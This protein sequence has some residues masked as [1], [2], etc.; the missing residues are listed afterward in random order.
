[1]KLDKESLKSLLENPHLDHSGDNFI[2][3]CPWC[4]KSE[5]GIAIYEK[6]HPFGC[7]RKKKC[8]Q[9]GNIYDLIKKIG[10]SKQFLVNEEKEFIGHTIPLLNREVKK[11]IEQL[12]SISMPI[13]YKRIYNHPYLKSRGFF[14]YDKYEVGISTLDPKLEKYYVIFPVYFEGSIKGYV[15][16]V[17]FSKEE[18]I[19]FNHNNGLFLER[20]RNSKT[21]FSQLLYGYDEITE[22][23]DTLIL[24]EG[25]F[26]KFNIDRLLGLWSQEEIKC[27][28][29]FGAKLSNHQIV[30]IKEKKIKNIIMLVEQDVVGSNKKISSYIMDIFN[31]KLG[32][33]PENID[34]GDFTEL[35][36]DNVFL[37]LLDPLQ[38]N[39]NSLKLIV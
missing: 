10:Y 24:V 21:D 29:T 13:G 15:S 14:E 7:F 6:N 12:D 22:N 9:T 18:L 30:K 33:C 37:N 19:D 17:I 39:L 20:F 34:P 16:R 23:T 27:C 38:Y 4:G 31:V 3:N 5:F 8:G 11:T 25:I 1:M 26:S 32:V 36:C 28:V 2:A 35:D